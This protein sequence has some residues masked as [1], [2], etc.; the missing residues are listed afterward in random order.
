MNPTRPDTAPFWAWLAQQQAAHGHLTLYQVTRQAGLSIPALYRIRTRD[1]RPSPAT[2]RRLAALFGGDEDHVLAL[3]GHRSAKS[4]DLRQVLRTLYPQAPAAL[5]D[6]ALGAVDRI[7]SS[8][9]ASDR[10][11]ERTTRLPAEEV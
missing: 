7:L 10:P 8:P 11:G 3:A 6:Q 9:A 5:V 1:S 2:C 4:Y